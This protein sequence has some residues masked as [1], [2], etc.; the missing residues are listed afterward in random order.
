MFCE[1]GVIKNL[2]KLTGNHL[3]WGL[4]LKKLQANDTPAQAFPCEFCETV[5]NTCT[6]HLRTTA[7]VPY[8]KAL[9]F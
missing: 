7:S 1:I 2:A 4:F 3:R 8:I 9:L 6:E 5:E